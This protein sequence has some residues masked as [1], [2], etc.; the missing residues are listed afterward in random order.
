MQCRVILSVFIMLLSAC[1]LH[2]GSPAPGDDS[3]Y[4]TALATD[5]RLVYSDA[6]RSLPYDIERDSRE[7]SWSRHLH[8]HLDAVAG[9]DRVLLGLMLPECHSEPAD[10]YA[11]SHCGDG[12]RVVFELTSLPELSETL[13]LGDPRLHAAGML[14]GDRMG[15]ARSGCLGVPEA[16]SLTL[17][18]ASA[19]ELVFNISSRYRLSGVLVHPRSCGVRTVD[20]VFRF[21]RQSTN[22]RGDGGLF[23]LLDQPTIAPGDAQARP[24]SDG[25]R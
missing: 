1:P 17:A 22:D 16:I 18:E 20:G 12:L 3:G 24:V 7:A 15:P 8:R 6:L 25:P 10:E 9:G 14:A 19:R 5:A 23:H 21:L 4:G 2:A 13:S 11:P